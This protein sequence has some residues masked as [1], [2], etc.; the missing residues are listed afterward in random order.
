MAN[1]NAANALLEQG[2]AEEALV[3][4]DRVKSACPEAENARGVACI[5]MKDYDKALRHMAVAREAGLP[6]AEHNMKFLE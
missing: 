3:Y 5:L 6:A 4:L 1:L 2:R